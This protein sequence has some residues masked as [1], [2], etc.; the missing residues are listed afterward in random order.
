MVPL[1]KSLLMT[2]SALFKIMTIQDYRACASFMLSSSTFR[3]PSTSLM[4]QG[5]QKSSK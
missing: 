4:L 2:I 1:I 3:S 5:Q